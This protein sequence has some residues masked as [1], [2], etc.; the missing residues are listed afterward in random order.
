MRQLTQAALAAKAIR[1]ELKKAFPSIKFQVVS[2]NY[3]MGDSVGIRYTDGVPTD[4][5]RAIVDKYQYGT[6]NGMIDLY[7]C[8][9]DRNDIP[10]TKYVQVSRDLSPA[11]YE[12]VQ[13]EIMDD[14]G[15]PDFEDQTCYDTF[16]MWGSQMIWTHASKRAF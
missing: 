5:V 2:K 10:Q 7:E 14:F 12:L 1:A 4:E 11:V 6:F 15:M 8:D 3:S 16:R 9:N 13:K